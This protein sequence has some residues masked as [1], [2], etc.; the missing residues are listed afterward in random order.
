MPVLPPPAFV[1]FD[2]SLDENF[3]ASP[4]LVTHIDDA[5][6]EAV[7]QLYRE[8]LSPGGAIL[9]LMSSWVSHL[10]PEVQYQRVVGLGMNREELQANPRLN[11]F[12]V[13]NLNTTPQLPCADEEFDVVTICVSIQYLQRPVEVLREVGRVLKPNAPIAIT[14]SNRCFPTKAIAI[15]QTLDAAGHARLVENY[16][17]EAGCW[18][19]IQSL[20]RS[21][22]VRRSDP[23]FAVIARR[24]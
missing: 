4:R 19:D 9:D 23:L 16:L 5:A 14:F 17:R 3:Y 7:T 20:D 6:I 12:V 8:L 11:E 13:Q 1:R 22:N 15:W 18:R 10:P 24:A 2:E 21:P